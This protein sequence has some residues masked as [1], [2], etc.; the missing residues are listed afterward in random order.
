LFKKLLAGLLTLA[1][2][3][4]LVLYGW[5]HLDEVA[6]VELVSTSYVVLCAFAV[7]GSLV[8]VG[9]LFQGMINELNRCVGLFE[10]I[11]LSVVTTAVNTLVPLQGGAGVRALYL[12]HRHGFEYGNF[13]A[14]LY[15]YQVLRVLVCALGAAAAVL[16]L[17][18]GEGREVSTALIAS[19]SVCVVLSLAAC[20][21][22]RM[23]AT[24]SWLGDRLA[25]F[26]EGWHTLRARPQCLIRMTFLVALQLAAEVATFWAACAAIGVR[27]SA[28]EAVAVGT[29]SILVTVVGLTPGGLGLFEAMA[30]F[31]S[32]AVSLNPVHSV[33]A[34]LL[35]RFVLLAVLLVLTPV[36]IV[37]LTSGWKRLRATQSPPPQGITDNLSA[38]VN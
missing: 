16:V 38:S 33:M 3:A 27:L 11:S 26:T 7:V 32:S 18:F 31:A 4:G 28:A 2:L 22:P 30:A 8:V 25:A 34:A 23:P 12:R 19:V 20:Y 10:C 35:A 29:L 36:A 17:V 24:G 5:Q 1:T 14:T 21:L 9:P 15:G 37:H 6:S 13:L